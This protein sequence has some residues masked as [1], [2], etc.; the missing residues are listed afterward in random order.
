MP[1]ARLKSAQP[2]KNKESLNLYEK[3]KSDWNIEMAQMYHFLSKNNQMEILELKNIIT[4]N[5]NKNK[6]P[7]WV[8]SIAEW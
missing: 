6:K 3:E 5:K 2:M 7:Q 1:R 4:K 8:S